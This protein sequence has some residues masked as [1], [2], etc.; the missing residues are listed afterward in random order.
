ME[1]LSWRFTGFL[2]SILFL[3][4]LIYSMIFIMAPIINNFC[5]ILVK[6]TFKVG[7]DTFIQRSDVRLLSDK[8]FF[9]SVF[10]IIIWL[11][12]LPRYFSMENKAQQLRRYCSICNITI[13]CNNYSL[14]RQNLLFFCFNL[15][16][17]IIYLLSKLKF[18]INKKRDFISSQKS[19]Q[20]NG[21]S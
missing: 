20:E 4:L 19:Y 3:W 9:Q 16:K 13:Q 5:T 10:T 14:N 18:D 6:K 17:W 12:N 8:E 1:L 21:Q 15:L 2:F 11:K 7:Q